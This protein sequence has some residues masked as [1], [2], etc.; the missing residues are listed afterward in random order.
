MNVGLSGPLDFHPD[1]VLTSCVFYWGS[2]EPDYPYDNR[3][4]KKDVRHQIEFTDIC[5]RDLQWVIDE[6]RKSH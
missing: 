2:Y 1:T 5:V 6:M 4:Y 3:G